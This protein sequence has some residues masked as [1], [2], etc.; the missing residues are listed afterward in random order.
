[1]TAVLGGGAAGF[2][3]S[4]YRV[5][6]PAS[7]G[8]RHP[9]DA[10]WAGHPLVG[11]RRG[12]LAGKGG[13]RCGSRCIRSRTSRPG[14]DTPSATTGKAKR[15][16]KRKPKQPPGSSGS[17]GRPTGAAVPGTREIP[18]RA[19]GNTTAAKG[20]RPDA[21]GPTGPRRGPEHRRAGSRTGAVCWPPGGHWPG[22]CGPSGPNG[23]AGCGCAI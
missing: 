3:D 11:Q 7:G 20:G 22:R 18:N 13:G 9:A 21:A 10:C 6:A 15:R 5:G 17:P 19:G 1:M 14:R 12:R 8:C 23:C 16:P 2:A 4:R